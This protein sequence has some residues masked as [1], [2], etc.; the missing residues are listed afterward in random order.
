M[1]STNIIRID[2]TEKEINILSDCA[3]ILSDL[4]RIVIPLKDAGTLFVYDSPTLYSN[5]EIED[6]LIN[7]SRNAD[8]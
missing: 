8:F 1:K 3:N 6:I 4:Q 5:E 7:I 2:L